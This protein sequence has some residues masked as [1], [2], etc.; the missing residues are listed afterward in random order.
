MRPV[1]RPDGWT[2]MGEAPGQ[3]SG[4][5]NATHLMSACVLGGFS[6]GEPRRLN[7]AM[8]LAPQR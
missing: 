7:T 1:Q 3:A 4:H 8:L 6:K 5:Q 2:Q